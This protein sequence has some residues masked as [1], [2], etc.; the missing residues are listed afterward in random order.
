V[1][2]AESS[3]RAS[4]RWATV[5]TS[6]R[7]ALRPREYET[8]RRRDIPCIFTGMVSGEGGQSFTDKACVKGTDSSGNPVSG[9][10]TASVTIQDATPTAAVTKTVQGAACAVERYGVKVENTDAV[11][12]P[13]AERAQRR[14]VRRHHQGQEQ[15]TR[16]Q[17][18]PSGRRTAAPPRRSARPP[19]RRPS[20]KL[21]A[22]AASRRSRAPLAKLAA[23]SRITSPAGPNS[24]VA[25]HCTRAGIA[26]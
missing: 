11:E 5:L 7:S 23:S 3:R 6:R 24:V 13:D 4:T 21:D 2:N 9:C 14:S 22:N 1:L 18:R 25:R 16:C 20:W 17:S 19:S 26:D 15:H 12:P 8:P 10:D